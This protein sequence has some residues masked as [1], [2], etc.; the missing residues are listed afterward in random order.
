MKEKKDLFLQSKQQEENR[1]TGMP[2]AKFPDFEPEQNAK[3][4]M[5]QATKSTET[6]RG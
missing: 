6:R 5:K 1:F 3:K 2:E 4:Q